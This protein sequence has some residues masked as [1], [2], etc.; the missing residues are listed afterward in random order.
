MH[1]KV[2]RWTWRLSGPLGREWLRRLAGFGLA[3]A[4]VFVLSVSGAGAQE[5]ASKTK[6]S[7]QAES[8]QAE[9]SEAAGDPAS[10]SPARPKAGAAKAASAGFSEAKE[11]SEASTEPARGEA[12]DGPG[13]ASAPRTSSSTKPPGAL[14]GTAYRVQLRDLQRRIEELKER[15]RQSHSRLSLLSDSIM[16]G[17]DGG[18]SVNIQ[19]ENDLSGAWRIVELVVVLDGVVQYKKIDSTGALSAQ[20]VIPI[21]SG[22]LGKGEHVVQV[23]MKLRGHGFGLFSYLRGL[24]ATVRN[25][26][27]FSMARGKA[28]D[29]RVIAW[30]QGGPTTDAEERPNVRFEEVSAGQK[31]NPAATR[32]PESAPGAPGRKK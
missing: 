7:R 17:V 27:A 30:E 18:G 32:P 21:F 28:T 14:D 29:L 4:L 31:A 13:S 12:S 20:K 2:K 10:E 11:T 6:S 26:Y 9:S 5:A 22:S 1:A 16:T 8:R 19:F 23:Q 15:I 24:D 3:S 25:D